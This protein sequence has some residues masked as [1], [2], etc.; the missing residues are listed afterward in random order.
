MST[1]IA[2]IIEDDEHALTI[3]TTAIQNAQYDTVAIKDGKE[4]IEKLQTGIPPDL[5]VLDLRLP[6]VPGVKLLQLIRGSERLARTKVIVVS[7]DA[8][9]TEYVREKADLVL[10]K[11]VGYNQLREMAARLRQEEN[12]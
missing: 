1:P 9:L 12:L 8:T 5:V 11:P 10:V 6:G 3:F 4:A 7:A 2:F